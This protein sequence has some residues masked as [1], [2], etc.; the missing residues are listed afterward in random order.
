MKKKYLLLLYLVFVA[1]LFMS[2]STLSKYV[3]TTD[4]ETSFVVGNNLFIEYKRGNLYRNK[5]LIVG[6]EVT[7]EQDGETIHRIETMNLAPKDTL[8]YHFYVTNYGLSTDEK[9]NVDGLF[10][11][12]AGATLEMPMIKKIYNVSCT[13]SYRPVSEVGEVS[14]VPFTLVTGDIDLPVYNAGSP[15]TYE[16][17]VE[18]KADQV[19]ATTHDDY[20]G[21]TLTIYLFIDA[22]S[23]LPTSGS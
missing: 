19:E 17:K 7:I 12:Q 21:S 20:F 1:C 9:N 4:K 18:V 3:S 5:Q 10:Y 16:F 22:A 23:D 6:K 15:M 11:P 2:S 8:V 14:T 13:I